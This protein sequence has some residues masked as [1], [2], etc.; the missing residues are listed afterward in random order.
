MTRSDALSE[1]AARRAA[2]AER[3]AAEAARADAEAERRDQLNRWAG[4]DTDTCDTAWTVLVQWFA[5]LSAAYRL[6][7]LDRILGLDDLPGGAAGR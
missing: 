3:A 4:V 6:R 7:L 2:D 1:I 5:A